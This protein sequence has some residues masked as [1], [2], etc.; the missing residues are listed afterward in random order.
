MVSII[1]VNYNGYADTC[2]FVESLAQH[3][4]Y[5]YEIIVVDNASAGG[6]AKKLRERYPELVVVSSEKNLGFAGGNNLGNAHVRGEYV[7]YMNN[8]MVI[9]APFLGTLVARLEAAPGIGAVSP[10]IKYAYARDTIQYAGFTPMSRVLLRNHQIGNNQKDTG[11]YD[12][13]CETA[14]LHGAC[15]LTSRS[16]LEKAGPMTPVFFLFYEELD[17]SNQLRKA[18]YTLWYE[19]AA[20]VYHKESRSIGKTS[21]FKQFYLTRGRVLFARRN[22]S[23]IGKLLSCGYLAT[24][25]PLKYILAGTIRGDWK[26]MTSQIR[27]TIRGFTDRA[28]TPVCSGA[29]IFSSSS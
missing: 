13:A 4:T 29:S 23:G 25:V 17:W 14:F 6:D 22:T 21:A 5:P 28:E 18:G 26:I 19:P 12:T 11:R 7:L 8:D 2:E 9:D 10:K 24:V 20:C 27:G 3:E 16:V 1:T 15:M